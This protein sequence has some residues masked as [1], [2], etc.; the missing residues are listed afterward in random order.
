M[1][2]LSSRK[3]LLRVRT[4]PLVGLWGVGLTMFEGVNVAIASVAHCGAGKNRFNLQYLL[5]PS[6]CDVA[7]GQESIPNPTT[8]NIITPSH[9]KAIVPNMEDYASSLFAACGTRL[10]QLV[11]SKAIATHDEEVPVILWEEELARCII[12]HQN[13]SRPAVTRPA[14]SAR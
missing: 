3:G 2:C 14:S 8:L 13:P 10:G 12:L 4:D 11:K 7:P 5:Q 9:C 6:S 1:A